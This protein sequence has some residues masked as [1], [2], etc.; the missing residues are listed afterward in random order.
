MPSTIS[1]YLDPAC[2][3]G[4]FPMGVLHQLVSALSKLDPD[5]ELWLAAQI[6]RQKMRVSDMT[7]SERIDEVKKAFTSNERDYA[8][9]L[10]L[11]QN[12]IYGV[13]IQPIA[14][15]IAKLRFFISLVADQK[16][17]NTE[18]NRGI[19]PLPNLETN[20]VAANTLI[21][22]DKAQSDIQQGFRSMEVIELEEQLKA[23]RN[24]V[25]MIRKA[26]RKPAYARRTRS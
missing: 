24:Q 9:K 13:D 4:A 23:V 8:R 17:N 21:G 10:F 6:E 25:F 16:V 20:F 26:G 11:I 19:I 1:K 14:V 3:S 7:L 18:P 22:L 2:G 15:Q 12:C 5:N